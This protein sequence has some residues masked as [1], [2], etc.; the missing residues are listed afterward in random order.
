MNWQAVNFDWNQTRSFLATVEEGSFSAAAR[1]LGL[2]QP[3]LSRQISALEESLGVTLFERGHRSMD[4]TEAGLELLEHVRAMGDA[5]SRISIAASGQSLAI[6]GLVRVTCTSVMGT[7]FLPPI[8]EKLRHQAPG[9]VIDI[10]ASNDVRD[11]KKRE[12]DIAIRHG[13][14][15]QPDLIARL[16]RETTAGLYASSAYLDRVGR[17]ETPEDAAKHDFIGFEENERVLP[18][19][20]EMGLSL[21]LENFKISSGNGGVEI[22]MIQQG[23]GLG[24]LTR[25][26]ASFHPE[27]EPVLPDLTPIEVPVWLVTHREL[28]TS[29]RIRL[30]YDLLAK[31]IS[32]WS[33]D[34]SPA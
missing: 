18:Y 6:E 23:L 29:R 11:L 10:V 14:P 13:R 15:E 28:H 2:T 32:A 24:V 26:V 20:Q 19:L 1:A 22:A 3:T 16:L 30:V 5:A 33:G 25:D 8:M 9:I 4:V 17:P 27:L 7:Y 31:E 21:T 12:A 34:G